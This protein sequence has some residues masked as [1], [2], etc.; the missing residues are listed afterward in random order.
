[1]TKKIT[2]NTN[3][4][5][6][7]NI[8]SKEVFR[9]YTRAVLETAANAVKC[10]FGPGGTHTT[11]EVGGNS[12]M[13]KD[14]VSILKKI[15]FN[16][17]LERAVYRYLIESSDRVNKTVGDGTTSAFLVTRA[18]YNRMLTVMENDPQIK[19]MRYR[20]VFKLVQDLTGNIIKMLDD[21]SFKFENLND[22]DKL[23]TL[24]NIAKISLNNSEEDAQNFA[25]AYSVVGIDGDVAVAKSPTSEFFIEAN[26]GYRFD[27]GY[28]NPMFIND[29]SDNSV[30]LNNADVLMFEG[31]P[32]NSDHELLIKTMVQQYRMN[33]KDLLIIAS[34]FSGRI[35]KFF[36]SFITAANI[37]NRNCINVVYMSTTTEYAVEKFIDYAQ[38]FGAAP[39]RVD[40]TLLPGHE[41]LSDAEYFNIDV[42]ER[43]EK[44]ITTIKA[45]HLGRVDLVAYSDHTIFRNPKNENGESVK[46]RL[47]GIKFELDRATKENSKDNTLK[48]HMLNK[49]LATLRNSLC[50]I[51]VGG[52][53]E[54]AKD[55]NMA[56]YDDAS[57]AIRACV[58]GGF[59]VGCNL[60]VP[61]VIEAWLATPVLQT[62]NARP[63][64]V[65]LETIKESFLDLYRILLENTLMPEDIEPCIRKSLD[66][67]CGLN[68]ITAQH[69]PNIINPTNTD[70]QII[71]TMSEVVMLLLTS[72]QF[73]LDDPGNNVYDDIRF[74]DE[75][76]NKV[77]E[78]K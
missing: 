60:A 23:P 1:M 73:L 7:N 30:K 13:T 31:L 71:L 65:V 36:E 9:Q 66:A 58:S 46:A 4:T 8:V 68:T 74:V 70:S 63:I 40:T 50:T 42:K 49:R 45:S 26:D 62:A 57:K 77:E 11:I 21:N 24:F 3:I 54:A 59:N 55:A 39:I 75:S 5:M 14:G 64:R 16:G 78:V 51:Y 52:D 2:A 43:I 48:I 27:S 44:A 56:L 35:K 28:V 37:Q 34:D 20:D 33:G 69:D 22:D 19:E 47:N 17:S 18:F 72:N 12:D 41:E 67:K 38:L 76:L 53:T 15:M 6:C 10:S 32:N 25:D 29:A 61:I